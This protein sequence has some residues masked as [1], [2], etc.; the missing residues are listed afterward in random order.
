MSIYLSELIVIFSFLISII[1][2]VVV[3]SRFR[4]SHSVV[5]L[6]IKIVLSLGMTLGVF[7]LGMVFSL[8][9]LFFVSSLV[10]IG[11]VVNAI[12]AGVVFPFSLWSL[13]RE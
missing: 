9:S 13:L 1:A 10:E 2:G 6:I 7:M 5:K 3:I 11:F 8:L 12:V 4:G